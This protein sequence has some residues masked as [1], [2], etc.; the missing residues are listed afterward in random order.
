MLHEAIRRGSEFF[1]S[2]PDLWD[3]F[4]TSYL[5]DKNQAKWDS[6]AIDEVDAKRLILFLNQWSTRYQTSAAGLTVAVNSVLPH[7]NQ[8]RDVDLLTIDFSLKY[9]GCGIAGDLVADSFDAI[10]RAGHR[11]ESTGASK[12]MHMI[13]PNL[14]VMWDARIRVGVGVLAFGDGS[15]Y[16]RRFLPKMQEWARDAVADCV[17]ERNV[18]EA[19]AVHLLC[20]CGHTLAKV[21]DEYNWARFVGCKQQELGIASTSTHTGGGS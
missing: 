17:R 20:P 10:A 18:S 13:S 1:H 6:G 14:F 7:L 9:G 21:I 16:S 15:A 8:L 3:R 5:R 2:H 19:E 4:Y 11:Y 12:I